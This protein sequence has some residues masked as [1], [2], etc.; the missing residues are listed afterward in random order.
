[1]HAYAASPVCVCG[2]VTMLC[3]DCYRRFF[4]ESEKN[5]KITFYPPHRALAEDVC[6]VCRVSRV[7]G[8]RMNN[9]P[10]RAKEKYLQHN[11]ARRIRKRLLSFTLRR[12]C[13]VL[14]AVLEEL[15]RQI[16]PCF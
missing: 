2:K 10:K 12:A 1:M 6:G 15:L 4:N 9:Y 16:L 3:C 13:V 8:A 11:S 5:I 14:I 7:C